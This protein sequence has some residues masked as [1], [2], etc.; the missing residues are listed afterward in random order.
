[1][2]SLPICW[3]LYSEFSLVWSRDHGAILQICVKSFFFLHVNNYTHVVHA[4]P[5]PWAVRWSSAKFSNIASVSVETAAI[6]RLHSIIWQKLINS[7]W[8]P[9]K[10]LKMCCRFKAVQWILSFV[11]LFK[12]VTTLNIKACHKTYSVLQTFSLWAVKL[13]KYNLLKNS[14]A[15]KK[16]CGPV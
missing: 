3:H 1:M 10:K 2:H 7:S 5:F 4:C 14:L 9:A 15:V 13:N 12:D 16:R 11:H 8:S 6:D